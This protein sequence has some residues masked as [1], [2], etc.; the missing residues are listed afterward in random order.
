MSDERAITWERDF[1][2]ALERSLRERKP[3][4]IDVRKPD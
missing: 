1:G 4:L 3:V 2:R